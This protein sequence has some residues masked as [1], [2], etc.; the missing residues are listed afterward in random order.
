MWMRMVFGNKIVGSIMVVGG[1]VMEMAV[2]Q[3]I[4]LM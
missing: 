2:I 3:E 4:N 1:I